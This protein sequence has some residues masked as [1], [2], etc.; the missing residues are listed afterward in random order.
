MSVTIWDHILFQIT[1]EQL[2]E[3]VKDQM[4]IETGLQRL[5]FC[6]RVLQDEKKL[7]EYGTTVDIN[8]LMYFVDNL[9]LLFQY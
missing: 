4:G 3:K 8:Y 2:K 1:V 6:G 5:I 7:A 9:H